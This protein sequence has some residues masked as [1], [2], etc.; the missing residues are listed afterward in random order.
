MQHF[1][2]PYFSLVFLSAVISFTLSLVSWRYRQ[3]RLANGLF[4]LLMFS[5]GFWALMNFLELVLP[6]FNAKVIASNLVYVGIVGTV[7]FWFLFALAYTGREHWLTRRT[8]LLLSI[9]PLLLLALLWTDPWMPVIRQSIWLD[10]GGA[11][12]ILMVDYALGFWVHSVYSYAL[13][14]VGTV[15]LAQYVVHAP[16]IY[17]R[18]AA[19]LIIAMMIPWILNAL[20]LLGVTR[21]GLTASGFAMAGLVIGWGL[22]RL[23]L[24]DIVPTAR[25][26]VF[27]SL[28]DAVITIDEQNRIVDLNPAAEFLIGRPEKEAIGLSIGDV[29]VNH[30]ELVAAYSD[31]AQAHLSISFAKD[32]PPRYYD[33]HISPVYDRRQQ[34]AARV[35]VIRDITAQKVAE[36]AE[37]EERLL[38]EALRNVAAALNAT[39]DPQEV[40]TRILMNV[41]KVLPHDAANILLYDQGKTVMIGGRGYEGHN[42]PGDP[43]S[44]RFIVADT[45]TLRQ[46]LETHRPVVI[47]DVWQDARWRQFPGLGWI[48]SY[49]GVPI[50]QDDDVVGF[51]NLD[52]RTPGMFLPEHGERLSVFA[53]QA[54]IALKN[55]R[56]YAEL[57]E[58]NQELDAYARTIAHDLN[59]P[60]ALIKGYAELL[61]AHEL[62]A[63]EQGYLQ[64]IV[65]TTDRMAEMIDQLLFLAKLRDVEETAVSVDILP[66]LLIV[67]ARFE[68]QIEERGVSL[69]WSEPLPAVRGH[70]VWLEEVLTNLVGNAIK[71][72][73]QNNPAPAIYICGSRQ[74]DMVRYEVE[75][76]GLGIQSQNLPGLFSMFT[77]YHQ[78][79]ASGTGLGLAIV[80]RIVTKLGG[81]VGVESVEGQGSTFWFTL[82]AG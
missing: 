24:L 39:L 45:P 38:A 13:L 42:D 58:R 3:G 75:D 7:A 32:D 18:Q 19:A 82:P 49:I 81:E 69:T 51:L 40:F 41:D 76:N 16:G 25:T 56:L 26:A 57:E 62:S 1:L 64:K 43:A 74:G 71:Y 48:G 27:S 6:A 10:T 53:D 60:L 28:T 21:L 11:F 37:R 46:M 63:V 23:R 50:L 65:A 12:P 73:G 29:F 66:V 52:A 20:Y 79:E 31:V 67:R 80:Q 68:T 4:A 8:V 9:E 78:S 61:T 35:V 5:V 55:A 54:A 70:D 44:W 15:F 30:P 77:R 2:N 22:L 34:L 72:I 47:S 36:K 17:R 59:T 33:V 14:F